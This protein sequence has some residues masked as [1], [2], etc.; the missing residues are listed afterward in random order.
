MAVVCGVWGQVFWGQVFGWHLRYLGRLS[1]HL[2]CTQGVGAG[3][4]RQREQ[5]A[6]EGAEAWEGPRGPHIP[7]GKKPL[8]GHAEGRAKTSAPFSSHMASLDQFLWAVGPGSKFPQ[9]PPCR[10]HCGMEMPR[11]READHTSTADQWWHTGQTAG[12]L[13]FLPVRVGPVLLHRHWG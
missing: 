6:A 7:T 4:G 1:Y 12:P 8:R 3:A 11:Q 5:V 13:C 9:G 10:G 2:F